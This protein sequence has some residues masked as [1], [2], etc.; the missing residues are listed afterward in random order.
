M[1]PEIVRLISLALKSPSRQPVDTILFNQFGVSKLEIPTD[2]LKKK[3]VT[4]SILTST[5]YLSPS[6]SFFQEEEGKT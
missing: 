4:I 3:N 6:D 2:Y 5:H 1:T